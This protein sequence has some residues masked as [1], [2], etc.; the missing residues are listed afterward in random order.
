LLRQP[1]ALIQF[2][3]V[4]K[5]PS[6]NTL[7]IR[8]KNLGGWQSF[9]LLRASQWSGTFVVVP[10]IAP[11]PLGNDEYRFDYPLSSNAVEYFRVEAQ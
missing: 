4:E 2:V 7:A 9:R 1:T 3:S 8:F 11:L 5:N 6:A 10:G